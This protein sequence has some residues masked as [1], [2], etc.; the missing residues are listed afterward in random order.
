[1]GTIVIRVMQK[2]LLALTGNAAT[3]LRV[4]SVQALY[5]TTWVTFG[6]NA[7]HVTFGNQEIGL[8]LKI[9]SKK[10]V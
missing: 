3:S 2:I 5:G 8:P 6:R 10:T 7:P 1:M 4:Q 9:T